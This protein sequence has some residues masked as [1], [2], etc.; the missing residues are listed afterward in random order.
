MKH[1]L[2]F[3]LTRKCSLKNCSYSGNDTQSVGR[4]SLFAPFR[5]SSD[6]PLVTITGG[7]AF[8]KLGTSV[9]VG[10]PYG[11]DKHD[12]MLA[13]SASTLSECL[14]R[15]GI[16]QGCS[17][18]NQNLELFTYFSPSPSLSPLPP[19]VCLS[20]CLSVFFFLHACCVC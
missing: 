15:P 12:D 16:D 1:F 20:V 19:S 10:N 9:A 3:C 13:I 5:H 8:M 17:F 7:Q 11:S 2:L 6:Q 18:E 14:P 4:V